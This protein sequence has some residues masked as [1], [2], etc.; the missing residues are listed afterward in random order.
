M[1]IE[2]K[3]TRKFESQQGLKLG[4]IWKG[5]KGSNQV[6]N[7]T[8]KLGRQRHNWRRHAINDKSSHYICRIDAGFDQSMTYLEMMV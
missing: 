4:Y 2:T 5:M 3:G 1:Q 7:A 8:I 6:I